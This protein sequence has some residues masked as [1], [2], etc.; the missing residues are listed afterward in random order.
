LLKPLLQW[1][2]LLLLLLLLL[3][4]CYVVLD[5]LSLLQPVEVCL[6]WNPTG[7]FATLLWAPQLLWALQ[8]SCPAS[9]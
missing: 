2:L 6:H 8:L 5:V 3:C 1:L 4:R 7:R 9:S